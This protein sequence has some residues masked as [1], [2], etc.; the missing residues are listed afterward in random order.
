METPV[1]LEAASVIPAA[2]LL[3]VP[4]AFHDQRPAVRA[5]IRHAMDRVC[6]VPREKERLIQC[7]RHEREGEDLPGD[8]HDLVVRGVVPRPSEHQVALRAEELGVRI[9]ATG[10]RARD[11][12]VGVDVEAHD[13]P[14][15]GPMLPG[16][17][18]R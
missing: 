12:D 5:D 15:R 18:E 1:Q 14:I 3:L 11:A 10:Q 4:R 8:P 16:T 7:A 6:A 13:L 9:H 2:Q 17:M